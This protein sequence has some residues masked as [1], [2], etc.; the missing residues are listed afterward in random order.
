M[1]NDFDLKDSSHLTEREA[2]FSFN[3]S[4]TTKV[5]EINSK[6]F[7]LMS[8]SEFLESIARLAE[9]KSMSP[10]HDAAAASK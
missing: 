9:Y 10:L 2:I 8:F 7:M 3:L 1:V 6:T 5:D 4:L